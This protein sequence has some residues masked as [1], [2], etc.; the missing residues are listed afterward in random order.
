[1]L[2]RCILCVC[3]LVKSICKRKE[4]AAL[5]PEVFHQQIGC[6]L[7]VL[8][9]CEVCLDHIILV[10][11]KRAQALNRCVLFRRDLHLAWLRPAAA[12]T[13]T[14]AAAAASTLHIAPGQ[15]GAMR[16]YFPGGQQ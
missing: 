11:P 16:V 9:A 8:V 12:A 4:Q 7:L 15:G 3:L 5:I 2:A 1:M 13:T 10:K 6:Q 14:A